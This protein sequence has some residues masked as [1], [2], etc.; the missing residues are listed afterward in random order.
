MRRGKYR[1][2]FF[3]ALEKIMAFTPEMFRGLTNAE[4]PYLEF[5][6]TELHSKTNSTSRKKCI[7]VGLVRS[8]NCDK[9][10]EIIQMSVCYF[11]K[12]F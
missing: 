8:D 10:N 1:D 11:R 6:Y 3:G 5:P 12:I 2:N 7:L 4:L 9:S